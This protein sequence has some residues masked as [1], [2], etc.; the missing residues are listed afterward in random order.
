[1]VDSGIVTNWSKIPPRFPW[2]ILII[3]VFCTAAKL[4]HSGMTPLAQHATLEIAGVLPSQ[5]A[6]VLSQPVTAWFDYQLL[7]L[8][9]A[10]FIHTSWLHLLANMVYLYDIWQK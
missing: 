7:T 4:L 5:F 10:L 9:S 8:I 1:M 2:V 3:S 6:L